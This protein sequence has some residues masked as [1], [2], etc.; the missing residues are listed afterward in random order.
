[1]IKKVPFIW[2]CITIISI[3]IFPISIYNK[4]PTT[5]IILY[6]IAVVISAILAYFANTIEEIRSMKT[7]IIEYVCLIFAIYILFA[8]IYAFLKLPINH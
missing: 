7:G 3:I 8:T 6:T 1:M 2:I 5:Y 4:E